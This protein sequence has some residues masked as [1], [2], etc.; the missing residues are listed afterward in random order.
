LRYQV[1]DQLG[2]EAD[3]ARHDDE[4]PQVH[5]PAFP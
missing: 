2:Q 1:A 5:D 4:Q 3:H